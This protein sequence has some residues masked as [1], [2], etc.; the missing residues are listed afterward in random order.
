ML[1]VTV[2][3]TFL[4]PLADPSPD[5]MKRMMYADIIHNISL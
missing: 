5:T 3:I 1:S 2:A 4:Y